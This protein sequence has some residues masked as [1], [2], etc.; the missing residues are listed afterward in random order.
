M[1]SKPAYSKVSA[2]GSQGPV[3]SH[4]GLIFQ[5][6]KLNLKI[7][8]DI[9]TLPLPGVE[10][11]ALK[12]TEDSEYRL[13]YEHDHSTPMFFNRQES[14]IFW[15][16]Y[17]VYNSGRTISSRILYIIL[18][19]LTMFR[20][21]SKLN[22]VYD[23]LAD[24]EEYDT[25]SKKFPQLDPVGSPVFHKFCILHGCVYVAINLCVALLHFQGAMREVIAET[26]ALRSLMQRFRN[27]GSV[28]M[29]FR[30]SLAINLLCY[31]WMAAHPSEYCLEM[32]KDLAGTAFATNLLVSPTAAILLFLLLD[33]YGGALL[34]SNPCP[35]IYYHPVILAANIFLQW[36][37][38]MSCFLFGANIEAWQHEV[39]LIATLVNLFFF[40]NYASRV[41]ASYFL[42][43][44]ATLAARVARDLEKF[45]NF[46]SSDMK[47][48]FDLMSSSAG[49]E[50]DASLE[51]LLAE[52]MQRHIEPL[53]RKMK[54]KADSFNLCYRIMKNEVS[55][56]GTIENS[57]ILHIFSDCANRVLRLQPSLIYSQVIA[58]TNDT[59]KKKLYLLN[60]IVS[61]DYREIDNFIAHTSNSVMSSCITALLQHLWDLYQSNRLSNQGKN[62]QTWSVKHRNWLRA[63]GKQS[64]RK[65]S[66]RDKHYDDI[67][68]LFVVSAS[69]ISSE[70]VQF[71][72]D[73]AWIGQEIFLD[74]YYLRLRV[75]HK[76]LVAVPFVD[77]KMTN[78][79]TMLLMQ[80]LAGMSGG[81]IQDGIITGDCSEADLQDSTNISSSCFDVVLGLSCDPE[82]VL[83]NTMKKN[84]TSA[85]YGSPSKLDERNGVIKDGEDSGGERIQELSVASDP[86]YD[87]PA[88]TERLGDLFRK[89]NFKH[90]RNP[91]GTSGKAK[92]QRKGKS[93]LNQHE[94]VKNYHLKNVPK[95]SSAFH[96]ATQNA[97]VLAGDVFLQNFVDQVCIAANMQ[98]ATV[99]DHA[100]SHDFLNAL[101]TNEISNAAIFLNSPTSCLDLRS[102]GYRDLIILVTG[103]FEAVPA[104]VLDQ[105]NYVALLPCMQEDINAIV[106]L[107]Q[108]ASE[109]MLPERI[110]S[111]SP[112]DQDLSDEVLAFTA[113]HIHTALGSDVYVQIGNK[114]SHAYFRDNLFLHASNA[115]SFVG[116]PNAEN[117]IT[118]SFFAKYRFPGMIEQLLRH[119]CYTYAIITYFATSL[120]N[121]IL[122]PS[123]VLSVVSF[124]AI[125]LIKTFRFMNVIK[126]ED[127]KTNNP[128]IDT[129]KILTESIFD[130]L[131]S[132]FYTLKCKP[133]HESDNIAGVRDDLYKDCL[134]N[135]FVEKNGGSTPLT[136]FSHI[137]Q[138][139]V[140]SFAKLNHFLDV[141]RRDAYERNSTPKMY[142]GHSE[143]HKSLSREY[144]SDMQIGK[145]YFLPVANP[146]LMPPRF[147]NS[148]EA[149]F[150]KWM[151][152]GMKLSN[153]LHLK[154]PYVYHS[155]ILINWIVLLYCLWPGRN[156]GPEH[157]PVQSISNEKSE[158]E[159]K[160]LLIL[161][162]LN[163][164]LPRA[165]EETFYKCG[166][167]TLINATLLFVAHVVYTVTQL[168]VKTDFD[169]QPEMNTTVV[170]F[171][172]INSNITK[173][174][175]TVSGDSVFTSWNWI[176]AFAYPY[177][178]VLMI[179]Q[180]PEYLKNLALACFLVLK[181]QKLVKFLEIVW[182]SPGKITFFIFA[183]Y[184]TVFF[185]NLHTLCEENELTLIQRKSFMAQ[186]IY[187]FQLNF[188]ET[189]HKNYTQEFFPLLESV[190]SAG[191]RALASCQ[192]PIIQR[193]MRLKLD[194]LLHINNFRL[195][196]VSLRNFY[197]GLK[198]SRTL[199]PQSC[200]ILEDM[201]ETKQKDIN[202]TSL[203]LNSIYLKKKILFWLSKFYAHPCF[204]STNISIEINSLLQHVRL[205]ESILEFAIHTTFM[206]ALNNLLISQRLSPA[207]KQR[208]QYIAIRITPQDV[209]QF[210]HDDMIDSFLEM[211]RFTVEVLDTGFAHDVLHMRTDVLGI[212]EEF[213]LGR[214]VYN[215]W[216][217]NDY[218]Q[219][220]KV[221][222]RQRPKPLVDQ[223]NNREYN[224][225]MFGQQYLT[226]LLKRILIAGDS[227]AICTFTQGFGVDSKY[228][229]N[230]KFTIPYRLLPANSQAGSIYMD[231]INQNNRVQV[232]QMK[233]IQSLNGWLASFSILEGSTRI[234]Y[235]STYKKHNLAAALILPSDS[236]SAERFKLEVQK[237]GWNSRVIDIETIMT[238]N[239]HDIKFLLEA[240]CLFLPIGHS[241]LQIVLHSL[242]LAGMDAITVGIDMLNLHYK[243]QGDHRI[244]RENE[245]TLLSDGSG[246]FSQA[247]LSR[248]TLNEASQFSM[249]SP[250]FEQSSHVSELQ[251]A[252]T[253]D[254]SAISQLRLDCIAQTAIENKL[255]RVF[256]LDQR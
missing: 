22:S 23:A 248:P 84:F 160:F 232:R 226:T 224:V 208:V 108:S 173:D 97:F 73:F 197:L 241:S 114:T 143:K 148:E 205:N 169:A 50:K 210:P 172:T 218:H 11:A 191:E 122:I 187:L 184:F 254:L 120:G 49:F 134:P 149:Y 6:V 186:R 235:Y 194:T 247:D 221:P 154:L 123:S 140:F 77:S 92:K 76:P 214:S 58:E 155:R 161:S 246:G 52:Q 190:V 109:K 35:N 165:G 3:S 87:A 57:P 29:F 94:K 43:L 150:Q 48:P 249:W 98:D 222:I 44:N 167:K 118:F 8:R 133:P 159:L 111:N 183:T 244:F 103:S 229:S 89:I 127:H 168:H 34:L 256:W 236:T 135:A 62:F 100:D 212:W 252:F 198:L 25:I 107:L 157:R 132:R 55:F 126:V 137:R 145:F 129:K 106:L 253:I 141:F 99:I 237:H 225:Y 228:G 65:A 16:N 142:Y 158:L 21:N 105:I 217:L 74:G 209:S 39:L 10:A 110:N 251:F 242:R 166:T 211:R 174:L 139:F 102:I 181:L 171:V 12:N 64:F 80:S 233:D 33:L 200:S 164:F 63:H 75:S 38:S 93:G 2:D 162:A 37:I 96:G 215:Y 204:E 255:K 116:F 125:L 185:P 4:N 121:L 130:D 20:I 239:V 199:F 147:S 45:Q 81:F 112:A 41:Y 31:P 138:E 238:G 234:R 90:L 1:F 124:E 28:I 175:S 182:T 56:D 9:H 196:L 220:T 18:I 153:I 91:I 250:K 240:D 101:T 15:Y 72:A 202:S 7:W 180:L 144:N 170:P 179:A 117:G 40:A 83:P 47:K 152:H 146:E 104:K 176:H 203:K 136:T 177:F 207:V 213:A 131:F 192:N 201:Q 71:L 227:N 13:Q 78:S 128:P 19:C 59:R 82:R 32:K 61:L 70:K 66:E 51:L 27:L 119:A 245:G 231:L 230:R 60:N 24:S 188:L 53:T 85:A 219:G 68:P 189:C 193:T 30:L 54:I 95:N 42:L 86:V 206:A 67:E 243:S 115:L 17:L 223:L 69:F 178:A 88:T 5:R 26:E 156:L 195:G 36:R 14:S 163:V 46:V 79:T 151:K 216:N 113:D